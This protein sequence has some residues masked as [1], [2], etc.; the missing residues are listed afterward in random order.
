MLLFESDF[1]VFLITDLV[2][3]LQRALFIELQHSPLNGGANGA[4]SAEAAD[5]DLP[6]VMTCANYL[7]LPPYTSKVL[8]FYALHCLISS[9]FQSNHDSFF[10]PC[11]GGNAK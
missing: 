2:F 5:G 8:S 7:K 10:L 11:A 4:A 1:S 3:W 6:S 9:R